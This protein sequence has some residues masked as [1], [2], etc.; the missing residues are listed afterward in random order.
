[1]KGGSVL[2]VEQR[3]ATPSRSADVSGD[4]TPGVPS[5]CACR[6]GNGSLVSTNRG[7]FRRQ[8]GQT[9]KAGALIGARDIEFEGSKRVRSL[10]DKR[11]RRCHMAISTG[12]GLIFRRYTTIPE[13]TERALTGLRDRSSGEW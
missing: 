11:G 10:Q 4:E 8:G 12:T 3:I 13:A 5:D 6:D 9:W 1:M 7:F 2:E